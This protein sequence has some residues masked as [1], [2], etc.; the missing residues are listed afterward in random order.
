MAFRGTRF[1]LIGLLYAV[2]GAL[3]LVYEVT[4][5]KY[6]GYVFG[7]TAYASSAVL[8]AF[9]GGLAVGAGIASRLDRHLR[10]PLLAY[11]IAE[12]VIGI[13]CEAVPLS[14][15]KLTAAYVAFA[16][17]HPDALATVSAFRALLAMIV[18]LVPAAGMGATLPLLA[19]FVEGEEPAHSRHLLARLYAINTFG[20]AAGSLLSAY[21]IIPALG[22]ARTMHVAAAVSVSVGVT[23]IILGLRPQEAPRGAAPAKES[24]EPAPTATVDPPSA[25]EQIPYADALVLAGASGLLVFTSEVVFVH[26][27]ALVIGTSVY[28]FGLMLAIFLVCL[29][30]GTPVATRLAARYGRNAIGL[31]FA[32]AGLALAASLFIWDKLPPLFIA[33]GPIV[34]SWHGR[35]LVRGLSAFLA[36]V[37][38]VVAMGTSFPLILRAVRAKSVGA[39]VGKLTVVNTLGSIAGSILGGFVLLPRLGSQRSLA[40]VAAIYVAFAIFA[41]R[42]SRGVARVRLVG[43]SAAAVLTMVL[44]PR[45]NLAR[46]TSGANVY[47]DAGVVPK[48]VIEAIWEDVH[49]GVT[50]VVRDEAGMRTLLT[51]GKFQGNDGAEVQDNSGFA[52]IPVAFAQKRRR[53][54]V[55]GLGTGTSAGAVA[56]YDFE[57]IDLLELSPAIVETARTTFANVNHHVLASDRTRLFLE[58]GRNRLLVQPTRYDVISIEVSSIW[59]AGAANLYSKEFYELATQRLEPGGVLQQWTQLH[60][61]NRRNLATVLHTVRSVFPHVI[62]AVVGHQGIIVASQKPLTVRHAHLHALEELGYVKQVLGPHRLLDYLRGILL[63]EKGIDA[64]VQDVAHEHGLSVD[65]LVSTDENLFLEYATPKANV[66]TADDI[67]DT[68]AYLKAYRRSDLLRDHI[69]P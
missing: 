53:A 47:F 28:A 44:L 22:L 68:I 21:W 50:T 27:L 20:G 9:M 54:M 26:L 46:L 37:V 67:P 32:I 4:F 24:S 49:G 19:R 51:N 34:R 55:I 66:P 40:L 45:W 62:L 38:P 65:D 13:F 43:V 48:G 60:H 17:E 14:F 3:G 10:R 59:F 23:A 6:L 33:L 7:A 16:I 57:Q 5:S 69:L 1:G 12:L 36:L 30:A 56:A 42:R 8:V 41:A 31:S 35:E 29:A 61:T 63:D 25:D 39:D 64:F 52:H 18:V 11:G 15:D 58:D 2:S